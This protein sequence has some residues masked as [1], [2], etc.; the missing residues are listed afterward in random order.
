M[1][2]RLRIPVVIYQ[3]FGKRLYRF[4]FFWGFLHLQSRYV[5]NDI[6]FSNFIHCFFLL[7]MSDSFRYEYFLL[8][9]D[10]QSPI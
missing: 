9:L 1:Y 6:T 3:N 7:L 2:M 5:I 4:Y 10:Y 8:L